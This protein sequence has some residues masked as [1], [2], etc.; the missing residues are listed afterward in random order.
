MAVDENFT[1]EGDVL[2]K[3]S[4]RYGVS[5][6]EVPDGIRVIAERAFYRNVG[7][8]V[9]VLPDNLKSIGKG[10]FEYCLNLEKVYIPASVEIIGEDAFKDCPKLEIY[11]EGEPKDG[12]AEKT[13]KRTVVEQCVTEADD[14][15][16]FHRS[17]GGWSYTTYEREEEIRISWNPAKCK[18]FYNI[19]R[20]EF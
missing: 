10:A 11:L 7:L 20:E 1:V 12:W 9:A 14:A 8:K 4:N 6:I 2:T 17:S 18:V 13:E 3:G 5:V 19:K 15:F 16:N